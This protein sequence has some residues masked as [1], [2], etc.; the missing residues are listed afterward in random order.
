MVDD[1]EQTP[2]SRFVACHET[3]TPMATRCQSATIGLRCFA[4]S[5][6]SKEMKAV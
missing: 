4:I 5:S 2:S 3:Q 1:D 6:G